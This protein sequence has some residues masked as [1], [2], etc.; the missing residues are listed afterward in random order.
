MKRKSRY[1][2]SFK[3]GEVEEVIS[4]TEEEARTLAKNIQIKKGN[5]PVIKSVINL[6]D[7]YPFGDVG[8]IS[9]GF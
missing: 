2:V 7:K 6:S 9:F 4:S 1:E 8:G 3:D 5:K